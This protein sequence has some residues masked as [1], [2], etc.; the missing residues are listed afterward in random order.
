M[1][2]RSDW[3]LLFFCR[4]GTKASSPLTLTHCCVE[5]RACGGSAGSYL[6]PLRLVHGPT[7]IPH[8]PPAADRWQGPHEHSSYL[9]CQLPGLYLEPS[10]FNYLGQAVAPVMIRQRGR[11]P[12]G[13]IDLRLPS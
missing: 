2:G 6:P 12:A 8:R 9:S 5:L 7:H 4:V 11:W 13:R 3:M 1:Y 10:R